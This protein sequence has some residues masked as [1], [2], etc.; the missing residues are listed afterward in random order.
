MRALARRLGEFWHTVRFLRAS[1]VF[2]RIRYR[3]LSG[4]TPS[5]AP[6][7][8]SHRA[9]ML[10]KVVATGAHGVPGQFV[11]LNVARPWPSEPDWRAAD[12][13]KLWRFNLHYFD[14]ALDPGRSVQEVSGLIESWIR[15]NP[16]GSPDAWEP[17]TVSLRIVNWIKFFS[18]HAGSDAVP[19]RA[20]ESLWQQA[21]WLSRNLERH[22]LANHY[23][24]NL[25]ALIFAGSYFEGTEAA[26]WFSDGIRLFDEQM[27]EQFL[28]DGAHFE[29]TP[30]YHCICTEDLLDVLNLVQ[31]QPTLFPSGFAE[32]LRERASMALRW[33]DCMCMPDGEI[34]LF[35]DSAFGIAARPCEIFEYA[36]RLGV[37]MDASFRWH[38]DSAGGKDGG[39][40]EGEVEAVALEAS[41]YYVIGRGG[42]RMIIDCGAVGPDYQPG[43]AH[44]DTLSYELALNGRRV[45]VDT[46][47][48]DY[49]ASVR[50][51]YARS[52]VAHNTVCV[53]AEEQSEIWGVFRVAR[54]ARPLFASLDAKGGDGVRFEGAHDGYRRLPGRVVHTRTVDFDGGREWRIEDAL[55]GRGLH[56]VESIVHIHPELRAAVKGGAVEVSDRRGGPIARIVPIGQCNV[57]VEQGEYFPEFGK[58]LE[59][60]VVVFS[61]SAELPLR[62]GYRIVKLGS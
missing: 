31:A 18:L 28:A 15:G 27:R 45:V 23:L 19:A 2:W 61:T 51:H 41:G 62:L 38:D 13:P 49:E 12:M 24:K 8:V 43:H 57:R 42:D 30:M 17:Y 46:G 3:V 54:R 39:K 7:P 56:S 11:F 26:R 29:R 32:K 35:N 50:R 44:C 36:E 53:D 47:V 14:Y 9:L 6:K 52:T 22:I 55:D 25:K 1:Q 16:P 20:F 58:A 59:N 34:A 21:A 40:A 33:F 60:D 37:K 10:T 48:H 4:G 5:A